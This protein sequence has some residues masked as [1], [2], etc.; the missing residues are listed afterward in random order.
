MHLLPERRLYVA[1]RRPDRLILQV[2]LLTQ[3]AA[4]GEPRCEFVCLKLAEQHEEFTPL[5]GLPDLH[6]RYQSDQLFPVF[7]NRQMPRERPHYDAFVQQL[8]LNAEADPFEVLAR[9]EGHRATDGIEVFAAPAVNEAGDL[10]ALF[11]ARGVR[12]VDG[13]ADAIRVLA[14]GDDLELQPESMNRVNG[15]AMLLNSR[16]GRPVGYAP[17]YLLDT[18]SDLR[19]V[20][21]TSVRVS[22]EH[23]NPPESAPHMRLLCRLTSPWPDGY[24]P[25]PGPDFLPL[26]G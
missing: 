7:A 14:G 1:W 17:D 13:A 21:L 2:G 15:R 9:S 8:D 20:D 23:A 5:P 22:V 6:R 3:R 4:D 16:T 19:S 25:L 18:I 10:A 26:A 11:F 24:E 12:H